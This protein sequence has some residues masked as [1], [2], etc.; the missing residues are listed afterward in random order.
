MMSGDDDVPPNMTVHRIGCACSRLP[1]KYK[2]GFPTEWDCTQAR[3][4]LIAELEAG[5]MR[6]LEDPDPDTPFFHEY[7]ECKHCRTTWKLSHPDQAYR[8][9]LHILKDKVSGW[10]M[11][12]P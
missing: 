2:N 7:F 3:A 8:G 10:K 4:L 1:T 9:G 12:R 11:G 6:R 5:N